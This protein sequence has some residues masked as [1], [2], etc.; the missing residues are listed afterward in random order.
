MCKGLEIMASGDK[1]FS[2]DDSRNLWIQINSLDA[3]STGDDIR[4][5]IYSLTC[6]IQKLETKVI[7]LERRLEEKS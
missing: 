1:I 2:G 6:E 7:E 4:D 3:L 5:V